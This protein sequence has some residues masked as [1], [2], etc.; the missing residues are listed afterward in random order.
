MCL[1]AGLNVMAQD[2]DKLL[3]NYYIDYDGK[4][5]KVKFFKYE[6][7]YRGQVFWSSDGNEKKDVKNPDKAKRNT[8][9]SEMVIIDKVVY[10]GE[11]VWKD[12]HIYDPNTGK[13]FQTEIRFKDEKTLE[14]RGKVGP[15]FKRI[16]WNKL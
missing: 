11:G 3:G 6:N 9:L 10:A 4:Q 15:F 5:S 8:P 2:A 14:V 1:V 16:Y 12:G 13:F 7:G